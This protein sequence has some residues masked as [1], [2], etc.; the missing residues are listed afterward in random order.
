MKSRGLGDVY[1]RQV[2]SEAEACSLA[3]G[4]GWSVAPDGNGWRRV[5]ASPMP[6]RILE[7]GVIELLVGQGVVVICAGGGGIPVIDRGDGGLIGIEAVIDK[8]RASALLAEQLGARALLLLTDVPAVYTDWDTP[9]AQAI[10][11]A[12]PHALR[13]LDF[14]PGSMGPKVEA[15]CDFVERTGGVSG[16]G[17]LQDAAAILQER[18]GTIVAAEADGLELAEA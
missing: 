12:T 10:S 2:Y 14:A 15:A 6:K 4:H 18:A 11:R 3:A 9:Q 1:K 8:D 5:V 16:I 17:R 13:A 7:I